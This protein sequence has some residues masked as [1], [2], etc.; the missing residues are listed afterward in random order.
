MANIY[1]DKEKEHAAAVKRAKESIMASA[2]I[3]KV[4]SIFRMLA[5][6]TRMKIV[7]ALMKG[8]MCVYHLAEV[9]NS[10][11]SGVSHQLRILRDYQI[12]KAE[13][14]GKSV[15]YSLADEHIHKIVKMGVKHLICSIEELT[16]KK[17]SEKAKKN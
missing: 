16:I 15:E 11:V 17:S 4:C 2:D 1:C 3:E 7:L 9:T 6:P 10:T 14:Q 8:E 5:E 12:V 13:R